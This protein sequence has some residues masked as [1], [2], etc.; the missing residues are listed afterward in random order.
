MNENQ[1]IL[2]F[3]KNSKSKNQRF[4]LYSA[5]EE[6]LIFVAEK[7]PDHEWIISQDSVNLNKTND[8]FV[9]I[10]MKAKQNQSKNVSSSLSNTYIGIINNQEIVRVRKIDNYLQNYN[11]S[12]LNDQNNFGND[13]NKVDSNFIECLTQLNQESYFT[14]SFSFKYD[15]KICLSLEFGE[16]N[17]YVIK[18]SEPINCFKAFCSAISI[19]LI[20]MKQNK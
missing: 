5:D 8:Y 4:Y 19:I 9:G 14:Q 6:S 17:E 18:Y 10:L 3:K 20:S 15:D 13:K 1:V 11:I 2:I 16:K 12:F 7:Q